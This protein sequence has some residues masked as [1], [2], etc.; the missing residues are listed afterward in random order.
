MYLKFYE[1]DSVSRFELFVLLCSHVCTH[2]QKDIHTSI[3]MY[4][5]TSS[6]KRVAAWVA[7]SSLYLAVTSLAVFWWYCTLWRRVSFSF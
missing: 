6:F 3:Y 1:N 2:V 4:T 5:Y 7:L